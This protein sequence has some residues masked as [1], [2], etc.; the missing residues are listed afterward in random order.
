MKKFLILLLPI[1]LCLSSCGNGSF[2]PV[3]R[4]V[5]DMGLVRV[6]GIDSE[7]QT[8]KITGLTAGGTEG[9]GEIFSG[10]GQTVSEAIGRIIK[11]PAGKSAVFSHTESV[12]IGERAADE[13]FREV[14]DHIAGSNE[15]RLGIRLYIAKGDTASS[16]IEK[17]GDGLGELLDL[18]SES[19]PYLGAYA[20]TAGDC[21]SALK[22]NGC[23]LALCLSSEDAPEPD[24][25]AAVAGDG[26]YAFLDRDASEGA[27]IIMN[28]L[29]GGEK[30]FGGITFS[31]NGAATSFS[32]LYRGGRL[33]GAR[34]DIR[35]TARKAG[36]ASVSGEDSVQKALSQLEERELKGVLSAIALARSLGEDIF[37]IRSSLMESAPFDSVSASLLDA[38]EMLLEVRL[39]AEVTGSFDLREEKSV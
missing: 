11:L 23:C 14:L 8:V 9:K 12:I 35:L 28:R 22:R 39:S 26:L 37:D 27:A 33:A 30:A 34:L 32:P 29:K 17:S 13:R 36:S 25:F 15:L 24:G 31:L 10:E 5:E 4:E 18:V 20:F 21:A 3:S 6:L 2:F 16:V 38:G 7:G 1:A 19:A